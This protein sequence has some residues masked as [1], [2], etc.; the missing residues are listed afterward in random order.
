MQ[1]EE[2]AG[3]CGKQ[4]CH[5]HQDAAHDAGAPRAQHHRIAVIRKI[6][7]EDTDGGEYR[8]PGCDEFRTQP[9]RTLPRNEPEQADQQRFKL[10]E[11]RRPCAV[12]IT[13]ALQHVVETYGNADKQQ[14]RQCGAYLRDGDEVIVPA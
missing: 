2:D 6:V 4:G 5:V 14:A 7:A 11:Q 1:D 13:A 12:E 3:D 9:L 10:Q 8:E